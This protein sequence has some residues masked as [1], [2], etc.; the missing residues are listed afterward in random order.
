MALP[1]L[2]FSGFRPTDAFRRSASLTKGHRMPI[3]ARLAVWA[4]LALAIGA[5][6][7]GLAGGAARLVVGGSWMG[8]GAVATFLAVVLAVWFVAN[9]VVT[10]LTAGSLAVL[11][12]EQ[13]VYCGAPV[14]VEFVEDADARNSAGTVRTAAIGLAAVGVVALMAGVT[15][16]A[17]A[18]PADDTVVIAD[19]EKPLRC[20]SL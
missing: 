11:L 20:T 10:T 19:A 9:M 17:D 4:V 7:A 8:F 14:T 2:L 15:L 12:A 1:G 13:L 5:C 16:L 3:A 18:R 6:V